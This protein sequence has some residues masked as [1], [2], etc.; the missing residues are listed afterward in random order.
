MKN[1][2]NLWWGRTFVLVLLLGFA[3]CSKAPTNAPSDASMSEAIKASYYSDPILKNDRVEVAVSNGEATLTGEV[4]SDA[5]RL[6]AYKLAAETAGIRKVNDQMQVKASLAQE[7]PPT[8]QPASKDRAERVKAPRAIPAPRRSETPMT[9]D[10]ASARPAEPK[11]ETPVTPPPPPPP[12]PPK[13][14]MV[15]AGTPVRVQMIDSVNSKKNQ[16]GDV[17]QAS[18]EA[19]IVVGDQ[20]IVPKGTDVFVKLTEAKSAGKF[21]GES[22][23]QLELDHLRFGG[24]DYPLASSTYK[25]TGGSRGKDTAKKVGIGTAIG[26]AIGA[27]AGGGK[28]AAIGAGVGAGSGAAAQLIIKGK[29]VQVPSETKLDFELSQ[30]VE[31]TLPPAKK[32]S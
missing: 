6:Q 1:R 13:K 11:A 31:I 29:E 3:A 26:A 21:K 14:V 28:G 17:F 7:Q 20:V 32:N 10:S 4:S 2:L 23:L 24:Q 8:E 22:E 27:I 19:P 25:E 5:A 30:P 16:V 9:S 12:P 18:L 15:S